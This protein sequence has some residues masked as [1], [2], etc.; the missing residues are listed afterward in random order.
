MVLSR[1]LTEHLSLVP[2][3]TNAWKDMVEEITG[4]RLAQ[5]RG[6]NKHIIATLQRQTKRKSVG[7]GDLERMLTDWKTN[8]LIGAHLASGDTE[9][10]L[11]AIVSR[12]LNAGIPGYIRLERH[13]LCVMTHMRRAAWNDAWIEA[14]VL[15]TCLVDEEDELE[16]Q[17]CLLLTVLWSSFHQLGIHT[18][19][20]IGRTPRLSSFLNSVSLLEPDRTG[21]HVYV[22]IYEII[23]LLLQGKMDEAN[24]KVFNLSVNASRNLRSASSGPVRAFITFLRVITHYELAD[25]AV[26][27]RVHRHIR[28]MEPDQGEI[29]INS[30]CPIPLSHLASALLRLIESQTD[31]TSE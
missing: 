24:R 27:K 20:A 19:A 13:R 17:R 9:G 15:N 10:A 28:R 29:P 4:L 30:L 16:G 25:P 26:R 6:E 18:E 1:K 14:Q 8:V 22:M 12:P 23:H 2:P 21:L 3:P 11:N 5:L 7:S 31:Q